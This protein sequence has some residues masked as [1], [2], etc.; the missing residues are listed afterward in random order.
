MSIFQRINQVSARVGR[1]GSPRACLVGLCIVQSL[2]LGIAATRMSPTPDEFPNLV[3]GTSYLRTGKYD[4]Y[5]VNPPLVKSFAALPIAI[6]G[7]QL[8]GCNV[9]MRRPEFECG[10]A[11]AQR[12]GKTAERML[13][14]GRWITALFAVWG[15]VVIFQLGCLLASERSGL[16]AAVLWA[17]SPMVLAYGP[18]ITFDIASSVVT[19]YALMAL[20][21]WLRQRSIFTALACG[22]AVGLAISVKV[23]C[24]LFLAAFPLALLIQTVMRSVGAGRFAESSMIPPVSVWGQFWQLA[25]FIGSAI[26]FVNTVYRFE[27]SFQPLG[28]YRFASRALTGTETLAPRGGGNRFENTLLTG[29]PVPLP[30]NFVEGIDSQ[31]VDFEQQW[32]EYRFGQLH[33]GGV[34]YYYLL[35]FGTKLSV[36][37]I[38]G[39]C[40]GA[41]TTFRQLPAFYCLVAI[42]AALITLISSQTGMNSHFRYSLIA[43]GPILLLSSIGLTWIARA[44]SRSATVQSIVLTIMAAWIVASGVRGF[45]FTHSYANEISGGRLAAAE[46]LGGSAADWYQGWWAAGDWVEYQLRAGHEV[47]VYESKYLYGWRLDSRLRLEPIEF[48][49]ARSPAGSLLVLSSTDRQSSNRLDASEMQVWLADSVEVYRVDNDRWQRLGEGF[50]WQLQRVRLADDDSA[51]E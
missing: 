19:M 27:G 18:L 31:K 3:A 35:G 4:L 1:G 23:T 36:L 2:L 21:L 51:A 14:Y 32:R 46:R 26:F 8:P 45:P 11:F 30:S 41:V 24:L 39:W 5:N 49:L 13:I 33:D 10:R 12:H 17:G 9:S 40:A 22:F 44:G 42:P 15:S 29:L 37:I 16:L 20:V 7:L 28:E 43:L 25:I 34:W 50:R 38:C 6:G 47:F 48:D